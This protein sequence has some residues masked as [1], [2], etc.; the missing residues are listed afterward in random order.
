M[1]ADIVQ[2][3]D[4]QPMAVSNYGVRHEEPALVIL[5][6]TVRVERNPDRPADGPDRDHLH[7]VMEIKRKVDAFRRLVE[8]RRAAEDNGE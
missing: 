7:R 3:R 2:I 8:R 4:Y 1:T 5:M 6:P